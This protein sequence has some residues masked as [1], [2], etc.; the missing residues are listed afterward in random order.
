[1]TGELSELPFK[2][3]YEALHLNFIGYPRLVAPTADTIMEGASRA[4]KKAL[5]ARLCRLNHRR[6]RATALWETVL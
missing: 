6:N 5:G 3:L 1:M 2:Q 4:G